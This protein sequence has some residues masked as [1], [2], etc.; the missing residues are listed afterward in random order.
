MTGGLTGGV[1]V[2]VGLLGD[3]V[4]KVPAVG[5][6]AAVVGQTILPREDVSRPGGAHLRVGRGLGQAGH[7]AQAQQ[8]Q[9]DA[10]HGHQQV[11]LSG[12]WSNS[13]NYLCRT[14]VSISHRLRFQRGMA[15]GLSDR[16]G[17]GKSFVFYIICGQH[18]RNAY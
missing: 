15:D 9:G 10:G 1:L 14:K 12:R 16:V 8:G 4:H 13:K 7:A 5:D 2:V 6:L 18:S 3:G 17:T 11:T